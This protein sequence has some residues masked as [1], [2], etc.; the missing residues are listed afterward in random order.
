MLVAA[1]VRFS[2]TNDWP[3]RSDSHCAIRRATTSAG[4][5]AAKP[6]MM[7]TGRVGY[8]CAHATRDTAGSAAAPAA[9][10]KNF[11]RG[12]FMLNPPSLVSLFDHLVGAGEQHRRH[13][14]PERLHGFQI[15]HQFERRWELDGQVSRLVTLE[16]P[17]GIDADL[18]IDACET[19]A[20]ADQTAGNRIIAE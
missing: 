12:S 8:A 17:T 20:V 5:P 9:R 16:N 13:V 4:P 18:T 14:Q 1:P 15:D 11:R 10:R 2:T 19:C 7:R 3:N 6:T